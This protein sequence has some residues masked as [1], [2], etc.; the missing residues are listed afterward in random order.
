MGVG[1]S[2]ELGWW[3]L[4]KVVGCRGPR[5]EES[6]RTSKEVARERSPVDQDRS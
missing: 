6:G 2:W 4:L 5:R 3:C 1:A